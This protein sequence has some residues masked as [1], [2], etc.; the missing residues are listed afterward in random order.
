[1]PV[2]ACNRDRWHFWNELRDNTA[3]AQQMGLFYFCWIDVVCA[4]GNDPD[5][6]EAGLVLSSYAPFFEIFF[7]RINYKSNK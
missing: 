2:G 4:T 6:P 5:F 3:A 1:M 7:I